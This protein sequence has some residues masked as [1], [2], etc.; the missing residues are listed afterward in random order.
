MHMKK[1]LLTLGLGATAFL[2]LTGFRG[3]FG[4]GGCG[5]NNPERAHQF[6]TWRLNSTLD[7]V[8]ASDAQRTQ[9][10]ALKDELFQEGVQ[11]AAE[12]RTVRRVRR[13]SAS[14]GPYDAA[15]D[16]PSP[17]HPRHRAPRGG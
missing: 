15:D 5:G 2:L 10:H 3:P 1:A 4:G 7:D 14:G 9:V 11:L 13:A 17:H 8:R 6:I 16:R 12:H